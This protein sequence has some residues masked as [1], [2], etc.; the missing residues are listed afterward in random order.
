MMQ[1]EKEEAVEV[2]R[3]GKEALIL[4]ILTYLRTRPG[5]TASSPELVSHFKPRLAPDDAL[6]FRSMLKQIATFDKNR[7][8][9]TLKSEFVEQE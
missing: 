7:K 2:L 1:M 6:L 3:G 8:T 9:W 4:A 5:N